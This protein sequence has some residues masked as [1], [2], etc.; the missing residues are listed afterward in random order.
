MNEFILETK[1]LGKSYGSQPAL[2]ALS[3][4]VSP[5]TVW[6]VVGPNGSGKST[7][8]SLLLGLKSQD[9]GQAWVMGS[10]AKELEKGKVGAIMDEGSFY[11]DSSARY[12]LRISALI[13]QVNKERVEEL[14]TK[15]G[16]DQTGEKAF[17]KFSYGMRKRLEVA[18]ALLTDPDL[19][20]MDE[21]I[22]GLDPEG[23]RFVRDLISQLHARGKTVLVSGHYL[24]ELEKVCT[25]YLVLSK[26]REVFQGSKDEMEAKHGKLENLFGGGLKL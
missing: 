14:L 16:L 6:G 23:I 7:L 10:L 15:L 25:H 8:F 24:D 3:W 19:Y 11:H 9:T 1:D 17:S 21:P 13:K 20:I 5:G 2:Q 12:N 26:G 4:K 18:D 22:N